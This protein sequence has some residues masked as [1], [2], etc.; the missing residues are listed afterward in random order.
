VNLDRLPDAVVCELVRTP[1]GALRI[2]SMSAGW[3]GALGVR[4]ADVV[5]DPEIL[6]R[7]LPPEDLQLLRSATEYSIRTGRLFEI[8]CRVQV[9]G[10]AFRWL[11][12][13]GNPRRRDDG[14]TLWDTVGLDITERKRLEDAVS[15]ALHQAAEEAGALQGVTELAHAAA[16]EINNPLAVIIGQ[17][18]LA[19]V[20][21]Q[22]NEGA[23]KRA[24]NAIQRITEIIDHMLRIRRRVPSTEWSSGL[25]PMLDIRRSAGDDAPRT[26]R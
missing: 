26:E 12:L 14:A 11:H 22:L 4:A 9:A 3:D 23:A 8:D 10:G 6:F 2:A 19:V 15:D 1:D 17:I 18:D 7:L 25:P 13:R 24:K 20:R 5:R 21:G 16:H